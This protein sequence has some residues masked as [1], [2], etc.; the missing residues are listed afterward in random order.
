MSDDESIDGPRRLAREEGI[1]G[2]FSGGACL[3]AGE[4]LLRER[5]AGRTILTEI[6]GIAFLERLEA[7][8]SASTP[9]P[10]SSS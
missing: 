7:A 9:A 5:H 8:T 10:A 3:V 2:G 4:R 1:F 6:G